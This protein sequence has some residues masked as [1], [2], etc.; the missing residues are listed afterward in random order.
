MTIIIY[1]GAFSNVYNAL[2]LTSGT[3]VAGKYLFDCKRSAVD[4]LYQPFIVKAVRKFEL[5]SSQVSSVY[6]ARI[7]LCVRFTS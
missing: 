3:N 5:T 4:D 2:D 7:S 1:S 6:L